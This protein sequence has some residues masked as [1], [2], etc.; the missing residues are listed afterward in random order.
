MPNNQIVIPEIPQAVKNKE[1]SA[2]DIKWIKTVNDAKSSSA[3]IPP[4][5][6]Y[7]TPQYDRVWFNSKHPF[8]CLQLNERFEDS[9]NNVQFGELILLY[10]KLDRQDTKCFTHLVTPIGDEV[11]PNPYNYDG[12]NGRWVWAIA[13]TGNTEV[14]SISVASTTWESAGFTGDLNDLSFEQGRVF[15][16]T[17]SDPQK[18]TA[19]QNE[20]WNKFQPFQ[21]RN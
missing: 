10:Q 4:D 7:L 16:I 8:F 19:I 5:L 13:M 6:I 18:L 12:W 14:T 17:N 9:L 1:F 3:Y 20:I 21:N 11:I 15:E 2:P